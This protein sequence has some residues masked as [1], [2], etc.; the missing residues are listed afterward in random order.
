MFLA[1][2]DGEMITNL[3]E[4]EKKCVHRTLMP[5]PPSA[6]SKIKPRWD[7]A[8]EWKTRSLYCTIPEAGPT[9]KL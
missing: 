6:L 9:I 1:G 5:P 2:A 7:R 4:L 3:K 8:N